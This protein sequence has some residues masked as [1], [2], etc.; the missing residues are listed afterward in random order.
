MG[1]RSLISD[2]AAHPLHRQVDS[3]RHGSMKPAREDLSVDSRAG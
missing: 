3:R 2:K 1:C